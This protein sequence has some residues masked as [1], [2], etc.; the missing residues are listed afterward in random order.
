MLGPK[1]VL[2][3]LDPYKTEGQKN[4]DQKNLGPTKFLS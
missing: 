1:L 2:K 3:I 4:V